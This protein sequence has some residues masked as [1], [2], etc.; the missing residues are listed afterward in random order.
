M[1]VS[2]SVLIIVLAIVVGLLGVSLLAAYLVE[3]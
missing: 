1:T 2:L 3:M